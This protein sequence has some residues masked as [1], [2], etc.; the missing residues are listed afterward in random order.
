[1]RTATADDATTIHARGVA[2]AKYEREPDGVVNTPARDFRSQL[3]ATAL[4]EWTIH[5][6]TGYGV[7]ISPR[8]A[9]RLPALASRPFA[10]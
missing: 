10:L 2:L 5:R 6:R 9:D 4:D 1:V 7:R 8:R 3:G